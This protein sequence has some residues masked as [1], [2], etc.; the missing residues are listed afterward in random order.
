MASDYPFVTLIAN[1]ALSGDA[2]ARA[3]ESASLQAKLKNTCLPYLHC[4]FHDAHWRCLLFIKH[5]ES[6][7]YFRWTKAIF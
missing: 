6:T 5:V 2:K 3:A 4:R 7:K 1:Q